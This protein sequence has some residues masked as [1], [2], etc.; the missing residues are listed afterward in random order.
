[1]IVTV[2]KGLGRLLVPM[3][4]I[5]AVLAGIRPA[6]AAQV[7]PESRPERAVVQEG[8]EAN[9]VLPDLSTVEFRGI[10]GRTLLMSGLVVCALGL[11]FGLTTFTGL[12]NLPV[13]SSMREVSELIYETG[14]T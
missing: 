12:R 10:N 7:Q 11:A 8:G 4:L 3:L 6:S 9:L 14:K 1:M 13:H 2:Q 5:R